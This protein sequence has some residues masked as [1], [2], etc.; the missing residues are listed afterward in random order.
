MDLAIDIDSTFIE[1]SAAAISAVLIFCGSVFFL[2]SIVTGARLAYFITA[3]VTLGFLLI[4]AVIWSLPVPYPETPLG[5]VDKL[6][7]WVAVDIAKEGESLDGP[8]ADAYPDSPWRKI[9]P[10]DEQEVAKA[11]ELGSAALDALEEA[12]KAGDIASSTKDNTANADSV[13]FLEAEGDEY[14]AVLLEP[15]EE[16]D[17]PTVQAV[18][19][20]DPG[21]PQE[22]A[23]RIA[24][25]TFILLVGHLF[26]LSRA[27]RRARAARRESG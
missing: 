10:E 3:S 19:R 17:A 7:E 18:L 8:S 16:G 12:I 11:G 6:P 13:R 4:M 25:G 21:N 26:F 27:E 14:G 15:A 5:P 9:D 22:T 20:F 24:G 1:G 2:L 23:R